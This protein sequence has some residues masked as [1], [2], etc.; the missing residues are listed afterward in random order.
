MLVF[1]KISRKNKIRM[2]LCMAVLL[3][4][5]LLTFGFYCFTPKTNQAESVFVIYAVQKE[6]LTPYQQVSASHVCAYL[7][8]DG[9]Q[10]NATVARNMIAGEGL[11]MSE[12]Q[13][14]RAVNVERIE[15]TLLFRVTVRHSDPQTALQL[16]NRY[17]HYLI[18]ELDDAFHIGS[19]KMI[20]S[21][22]DTQ[23]T[24]SWGSV[25]LKA[26]LGTGLLLVGIVGVFLYRFWKKHRA[27]TAILRAE[28]KQG[29]VLNLPWLRLAKKHWIPL[30]AVFLGVALILG[31][32]LFA[33]TA[34]T[35]TAT[36]MVGVSLYPASAGSYTE[37]MMYQNN[38]FFNS[39]TAYFEDP[40]LLSLYYDRLTLAM[41]QK[42]SLS[43]LEQAFSFQSDYFG[44]VR[45][46]VTLQNKSDAVQLCRGFTAFA[47][48]YVQQLIQLGEVQE[49]SASP[50]AVDNSTAYRIWGPAVGGAVV[51][52]LLYVWFYLKEKEAM[53]QMRAV[54]VAARKSL[55]Q[56]ENKNM[57]GSDPSDTSDPME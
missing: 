38:E 20:S 39:Y 36:Q 37:E 5:L 7:L 40:V 32:V 46:D 10:G 51:V 15:N 23:G 26:F 50:V 34:P 19:Y 42:Y 49:L 1:S 14:L 16:A 47:F 9:A 31:V 52:L 17:P 43:D 6:N 28:A 12:K 22:T 53:S 21:D 57:E 13:L 44:A 54:I 8:N 48:P 18:E 56:F 30:L 33:F 29:Y 55:Q 24:F 27:A 25:L 4:F 41:Q 3:C 35:V 11:Q 45:V 2:I